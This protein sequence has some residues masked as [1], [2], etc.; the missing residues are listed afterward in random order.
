[1]KI[2]FCFGT[3]CASVLLLW[4]VE[5]EVY[6]VITSG[7]STRWWSGVSLDFFFFL[8]R[9]V[10]LSHQ[11]PTTTKT[12]SKTASSSITYITTTAATIN[13]TSKNPPPSPPPTITTTTTSTT[14]PCS[15]PFQINV[16]SASDTRAV[17][18]SYTKKKNIPSLVSPHPPKKKPLGSILPPIHQAF[19]L[20]LFIAKILV[21]ARS[22]YE[23]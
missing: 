5:R 19:F 10:R 1:M 14:N 18:A 3:C 12:I 16:N 11:W 20:F 22:V 13:M 6:L 4:S 15:S 17:E 21:L 23:V 7:G 9:S 8:W 2:K